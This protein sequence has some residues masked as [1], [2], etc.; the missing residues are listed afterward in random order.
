MI[1]SDLYNPI[2]HE[3]KNL[4]ASYGCSEIHVEITATN[5]FSVFL[6]EK[7]GEVLTLLDK[8]FSPD[9]SGTYK[10]TSEKKIIVEV[11][12]D[13]IRIQNIYQTISYFE[14]IDANIGILVSPNEIPIRI[15]KF[16]DRKPHLLQNKMRKIFIVT[17]NLRENKFLENSWY[18]FQPSF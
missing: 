17:F 13:D 1:E 6:K 12:K 2:E 4:L 3:M 11:K 15:K 5:R 7:F 8:S 9:L 18:P 14:L 10:K 16:L